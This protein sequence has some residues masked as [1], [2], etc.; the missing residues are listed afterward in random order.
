MQKRITPITRINKWFRLYGLYCPYSDELRYIGITTGLLSTRLSGHLRNPTN[1][2]IA[3]WFKELKLNDK[4]PIIK[5][6]RE[7]DSYEDLLNAEIKEIKENRKKTNKLLNIADGGDINPMFG[8]THTQEA[9]TKISKTHKGRKLSDEQIKNRKELLSKLW[10]NEEW[11]EIL[12]KKMSENMIGNCRAVGYKHSEETKKMLSNLHKNNK[13]S[14]GFVHSDI[15][16]LKMSQ[17][18]SGENNP[19]FGRTLPKEV[20]LKRSDKVKKEGTFKGKNNGNFKYDINKEEL[21][22]LYLYKNLKIS[23]IA[24]LYGCHRT[25]ISDN[26]KKYGIIKPPSNK[27]N[28]NI[29]EIKNYIKEG[30]SLVQIGNKYGCSNKIIHKFI[31]K[32]ER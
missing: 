7:Y 27:Y 17:N 8:K 11:S 15:T 24:N 9:R 4:K 16:K 5:L 31:K 28:L 29:D 19:M 30:L 2:K 14:L 25:V 3:L 22:E 6:I 32:H 26:I 10:S 1:G 21:K 13:Y 23:E 20:L 12:K 18:N